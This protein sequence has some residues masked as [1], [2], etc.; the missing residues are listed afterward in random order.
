MDWIYQG[1]RVTDLPKEVVGFVYIIYYANGKKYIGSKVVRSLRKAKPLKHMRKNARRLVERESDWREYQGSSKLSEG[2][3][4]ASK[5]ILW[6]CRDKRTMT[7]MEQKELMC[8][9]AVFSDEYLNENVG[10]RFYDNC[11]NLYTEDIHT[12]SLFD[13]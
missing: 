10:G 9:D 11:N 3:E 6:L 2:L 4:I 1:K 8:R 7:Y 5:H 13:D 12:R